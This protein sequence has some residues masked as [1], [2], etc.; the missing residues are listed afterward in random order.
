MACRSCRLLSQSLENFN[1]SLGCRG[2][3]EVRGETANVRIDRIR[4]RRRRELQRRVHASSPMS[5]NATP[6]GR[7]AALRSAGTQE[8]TEKRN[9]L[10]AELQVKNVVDF[11]A[12]LRI[13]T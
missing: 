5:A 11:A 4:L 6:N 13:G 7:P 2:V 10:V 8:L 12:A 9:V 1:D 3:R